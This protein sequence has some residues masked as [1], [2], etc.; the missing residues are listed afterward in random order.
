MNARTP[1][2][3]REKQTVKLKITTYMEISRSPVLPQLLWP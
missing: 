2:K 1:G 3:D